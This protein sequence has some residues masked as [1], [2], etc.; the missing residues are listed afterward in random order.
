M[1]ENA[2]VILA[3]VCIIAG[4][5]FGFF[6]SRV[7][8]ALHELRREAAREASR[9]VIAPMTIDMHRPQRARISDRPHIEH[10]PLI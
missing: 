8:S 10:S 7:R 2:T 3:C 9:P 5:V 4:F 1:S 6:T